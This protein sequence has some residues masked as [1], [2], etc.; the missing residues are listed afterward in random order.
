MK[1]DIYRFLGWVIPILFIAVAGWVFM[2][3]S[4]EF[5]AASLARQNSNA[6]REE[7]A[8]ELDKDKHLPAEARYAAVDD[9][10]EEET[11]FLTYLRTR[12]AAD[13]VGLENWS[14]QTLE[15]GKDK[16]NVQMDL[17]TTMLLKGIR[18]ISGA[19]TLTGTYESIRA[20]VGELESSPRLYTISNINWSVSKSGT[21]LAMT[22][23]RY[24]GP[25]K[26]APAKA[27]SP[28]KPASPPNSSKPAQAANAK[29]ARKST[30]PV[31]IQP[32]P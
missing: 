30:A 29:S 16:L 15:Y 11:A 2:T 27:P 32:K 22:I 9:T 26:E 10:Q 23:S 24:V 5:A 12:A 17:Q 4:R 18:K 13:H 31:Q 19:L 20:L 14:S 1:G 6:A 28:P 7:A 3:E 25:A 21:Q 8:K